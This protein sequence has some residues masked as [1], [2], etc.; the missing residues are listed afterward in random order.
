MPAP[1]PPVARDPLDDGFERLERLFARGTSAFL[2]PVDIDFGSVS[3]DDRVLELEASHCYTFLGFATPRSLDLNL[4]LT[5]PSGAVVASDR[6]PDHFPVLHVWCADESGPHVLRTSAQRGRGTARIGGY[7]VEDGPLAVATQRLH[8]LR[9]SFVPDGQP[10]GAVGRSFVAEGE[11]HDIA[12][13]VAAGACV[14]AVATGSGGIEDLDLSWVRADG[15]EPVRDV[16]LPDVAVATALCPEQ[17]EAVRLRVT[18]YA[19]AGVAFWQ[20][21]ETPAP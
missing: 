13:P 21:L 12:V 1:Q 3:R 20:V 8:A 7:L 2:E 18:A 11:D 19:G 4:E 6:I 14:A 15:S 9:A 17:G 5:D 10:A 16:G